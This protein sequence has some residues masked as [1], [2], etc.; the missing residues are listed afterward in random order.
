MKDSR[1]KNAHK[2]TVPMGLNERMQFDPSDCKPAETRH[3]RPKKE[4]IPTGGKQGF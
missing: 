3:Q 1:G 2:G 4:P